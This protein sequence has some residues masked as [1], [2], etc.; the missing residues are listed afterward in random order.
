MPGL[1][2]GS[3]WPTGRLGLLTPLPH[4]GV[5]M[6]VRPAAPRFA[7]V[8]LFA[9][10]LVTG[11][12]G[13]GSSEAKEEKSPPPSAEERAYYGCLEENGVVL[14]ERDDGALRVDKDKNKE[15]AQAAAQT[16]CANLLPSDASAAPAPAAF[17][18]KAMKFSA[19]VRENG[20]PKYPDPDPKTGQVELGAGEES[21]YKTSEFRVAADKC[22]SDS[23]GGISGG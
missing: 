11:C 14:E 5:S 1:S 19:C 16:K 7:A 21:A 4:I 13:A 8:A 23:G 22:S 2:G 15:A 18:A 6:L 10:V 12:S 17:V 9:S 3:V 20:F